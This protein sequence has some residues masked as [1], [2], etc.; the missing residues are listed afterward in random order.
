MIRFK[1]TVTE[2]ITHEVERCLDVSPGFKVVLKSLLFPEA[3]EP[4]TPNKVLAIKAI[5]TEYQLG[6]KEAKDMVDAMT[7]ESFKD[8]EQDEEDLRD[9]ALG[10]VHAHYESVDRLCPSLGQLL[11][12]KLD[13]QT[14][15]LSDRG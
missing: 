4:R 10:A 5:R 13:E 1:Q 8:E 15:R 3:W 2:T 14:E 12:Q 6:L 7:P 11:R 9:A